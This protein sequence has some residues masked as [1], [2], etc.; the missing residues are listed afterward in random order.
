MGKS[1]ITVRG[2]VS[3]HRRIQYLEDECRE[4]SRRMY[5]VV[6]EFKDT[7]TSPRH[8][9]LSVQKVRSGTLYL[10]WRRNG[11]EAEQ[12]YIHFSFPKGQAFLSMLSSD[13]RT[14]YLH[15]N[16]LA[17]DLTLAHSMRMNEIRRLRQYV[18]DL[19]GIGLRPLNN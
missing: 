18:R 2:K 11:T 7:M 3:A 19:E 14:V 5:Q 9:T 1:L 17:L 10:R 6:V 8:L 13:I 15:Y 16:R 12:E 4:I